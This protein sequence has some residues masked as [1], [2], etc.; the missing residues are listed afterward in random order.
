MFQL[1]IIGKLILA[2]LLGAIIGWE[3]KFLAGRQAGI[4]TCTLVAMGSALFTLLSIDGFAG[5]LTDPS[6]V[7]AQIVVGIGF[8]GAGTIM[9]YQ[10]HIEGLTTAA[11]LWFIAAIGMAVAVDW[12]L[13]A[14]VT[15]IVVFTFLYVYNRLSIKKQS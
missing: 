5:A 3:R 7:A 9:V 8:L 12:Y 11:G 10:G 4:K 2:G 1:I 14:V 13:V 15:T 6:R